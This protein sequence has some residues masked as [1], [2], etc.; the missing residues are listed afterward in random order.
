MTDKLLTFVHDPATIKALKLAARFA[1]SPSPCA[2]CP[3]MRECDQAGASP[4]PCEWVPGT[5]TKLVE[6]IEADGRH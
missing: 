1:E 4:W 2:T 3:L 5:L 6:A